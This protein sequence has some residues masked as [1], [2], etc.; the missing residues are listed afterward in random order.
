M[1]QP[2]HDEGS[3]IVEIFSDGGG[4]ACVACGGGGGGPWLR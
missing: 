4:G 3:S 2:L 1:S